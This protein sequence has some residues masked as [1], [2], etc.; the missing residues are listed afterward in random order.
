MGKKSRKVMIMNHE[1]E[2]FV[3]QAIKKNILRLKDSMK[4]EKDITKSLWTNNIKFTLISLFVAVIL[5][6]SVIEAHAYNTDEHNTIQS[7][8]EY[9]Y[10]P[11]CI[12]SKDGKA[13]GFSV[14]L[15]K[16]TLKAV[17][18]D[19]QFTIG[20]W[21]EVKEK[22]KD[23]T[24]QVLPLVGRTPEREEIFDFTFP[25]L[26][27]HGAI[28]VKKGD[29]SINSVEDLSDKKVAVM[30]GDNAEEFA[31]RTNVSSNIIAVE[32]YEQAIKMLDAGKCDAVI[33]QYIMGLE[34][35]NDMKM[36]TVVPL[37]FMLN[38]FQQNFCFAVREGDK[39]LLSLLNEGLSI[40]IA[41]GTFDELH[42]KWFSPILDNR[43]SLKHV[44]RYVI[45]IF[46]P[47]AIICGV[48][49]ILLL[50]HQVKKKT[51][52]LTKEVEK[53]KQTESELLKS[54]GK[55]RSLS[56]NIQA[57]IVIHAP[58]T[59]IIH[60]NKTALY[61]LG[62]S[63]E[64]IT[65]K[66]A[67]NP[68][69]SFIA[70]DGQ[71]MHV[72]EYPVMKVS[73]SLK[74]IVDLV[75]GVNRPDKKEVTW[76]LVN[77]Y[78]EFDDSN[79]LSNIGVTFVDITEREN[80]AK[81]LQKTNKRHAEM[82]ENI[83]DV[84]SIIDTDG[85][86][87]YISPN[88]EKLS[89]STPE[90]LQGTSAW[91]RVHP[92]DL[93][94]LQNDFKDLLKNDNAIKKTEYRNK[95]KDGNYKWVEI[96]A[97]NRIKDN[98]INGVLLNYHDITERKQAD[99]AL[100]NSK[101]AVQNKLKA[102]LE[103]EGNIE[104]LELSDVI[105]SKAVQS[106]M[107]DFYEL[108]GMLGAL[109]DLSG[110]VLVAVGWQDICTKFHRQNPESC[111]NCLES[112]TIL[113]KNVQ[114][115][116]FKA[117]KCKNHLWDM[118]TPLIV[119]NRHIGNVFIGQFFYE[120][121]M[122]DIELFK[123]QAQLYG[124][125][126]TEYLAALELVPHFTRETV[127]T[128]MQFY[129]KLAEIISTLSYNAINM[130]RTLAE[131]ER[132]KIALDAEKEQ[133]AVTLRSIGDGV[134][135][136]DTQGKIV[137]LNKVAEKLTEW[138]SEEA[139]G[140]PLAEV[141][142]M[143][144]ESTNKKCDSPVEKVI[145]TGNIVELE[146]HTCLI[147]KSGTE[148]IIADSAAPIK[149]SKSN[150][151][152]VIIVFRDMTEKNRLDESIQRTQ[153]L[154]SLGVLAGGIAH[155]F[156]NLLGGIFGYIEMAKEETTDTNVLNLLAESLS[157]ID[158]A[159]GLTQQ[160]LT[161]SKGGQPMKN[162]ETLVPFAK[163]IVQFAL[164]GT[165]VSCKFDIQDKLWSSNFD[166]NQI[167]QVIENLTINAQQAMPNGGQIKLTAENISIPANKHA[168][169]SPGNYVKISLKDYGIG[170]P[171][172]FLARIFDP[173]YTTKSDGHGLG[174]AS[175]Y[176]IVKK[177]DGCIDVQSKPGKGSTF[178]LYLPAVSDAKS[179]TENKK[180]SM[181]KGTGTFLVMDDEKTILD[182]T[183]RMLESFGY[184][185]ILAENGQEA[186]D[187]FKVSKQENKH[188]AG[189]IFDLTISG[190]M[191]GKEAI[192]EIRKICK[193]TPAFVS[194]GYSSDPIMAEP[195]KYGFNAS[196]CKPFMKK[197]LSNMLEKHLNQ[198]N[199]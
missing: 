191:G 184:N 88:S 125:D 73:N 170:I 145:E 15:L 194:S 141:L 182:I 120:D 83:G 18:L 64:Q 34:L 54:E 99:V 123:Q 126:E 137:M 68:M 130:A 153:K 147:S 46:I 82:L 57:G 50:R 61:L 172:E 53:H 111:K 152:G 199:D 5:F 84:I 171:R 133:L 24:I 143:V 151:I 104:V 109:L 1:P 59:S 128:C 103:P 47:F 86:M 43:I 10:P 122:P 93:K 159:K 146:N 197:E 21:T 79:K 70:K 12:V 138:S 3:C 181:H 32:T 108:T 51:Y 2:R 168:E 161:F 114:P 112:D 189:M 174:L 74:P 19:V 166:K 44:I 131:R 6:T 121:E 178:N 22:L 92:D 63:E 8:C 45:I 80:A 36:K 37:D 183:K 4:T 65:G 23:G 77:A 25:Y 115:G 27:V 97:V 105:D 58:D 139:T 75:L 30:K 198:K 157:S 175:C 39:Q 162:I 129:V 140:R 81:V 96:N 158:R 13:D 102:I 11:F 78:P 14:E 155:D 62:L 85:V 110:N 132:A 167:A 89:G 135:T 72:D 118:V 185:V 187:F 119:G 127:N 76:L 16:E 136:T 29:N 196:I 163:D 193:E 180:T 56:E 69:W 35:L 117:Y 156:N 31:R 165:S 124:F 179:T 48:L 28:F 17:D 134:I 95:C 40:V 160:L 188:I 41:N 71:H 60:Y 87:T 186:V 100:K 90:E 91:N 150:I 113:T 142:N 192:D 7:G 144:N 55:Y 106:I 116:K 169:L 20:P 149:D 164:S 107:E 94:Q 67:M 177:H 176:S 66:K 154:E 9:D 38:N 148:I 98:A 42:Q 26:T 101:E 49:L 195:E 173:Y 33:A 52:D 190:G